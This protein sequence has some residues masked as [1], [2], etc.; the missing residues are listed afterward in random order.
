MKFIYTNLLFLKSEYIKF[1]ACTIRSIVC[2][3]FQSRFIISSKSSNQFNARDTY[4]LKIE[5]G[6]NYNRIR[7]FRVESIVIDHSIESRAIVL[8]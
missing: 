4:I 8:P 7:T 6:T 5:A 3:I 1:C 2:L